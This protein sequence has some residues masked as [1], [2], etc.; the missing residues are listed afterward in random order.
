MAA[1]GYTPI[2]PYYSITATN[3]PLAANMVTGELAINTVDGK[4]YFKNSAGA[5]TLIAS[6]ASTAGNAIN[7]IGGGANQLIY[8]TGASTT[9]FLPAP[10]T[11]NTSLVWN[12]SSFSWGYPPIA[13]SVVNTV[14]VTRGGTGLTAPTLNSLLVGA[15]PN[16]PLNTIA[17]GTAGN[18]LTSSIST[19]GVVTGSISTTTLSVTAVTSGTLLIGSALSG[20]IGLVT[21]TLVTGQ[22]NASG[23]TAFSTATSIGGGVSGTN[24]IQFSSGTVSGLSVGNFIAGSGLATGTTVIAIGL[25]GVS[26]AVSNNFTVSAAVITGSIAGTTLNVTAVASGTLTSGLILSGTSVSSG[27][28]LSTQI[29]AIGATAFNSATSTGGGVLGTNSIQ[30]A[31]GVISTLTVGNFITGTGIPSGTSIIGI[32]GTTVTLSNVF[33]IAA[34]GTYSFYAAGKIG[35]YNVS[36]SQTAASQT[37]T[38]TAL[39]SYSFYTAGGIGTYVV[40]PSQTAASSTIT[41]TLNNWVSAATQP[42]G[43]LGQVFTSSGTFT[44]PAGVTALKVTVVGGGGSGTGYTGSGCCPTYFN[45]NAGG[46]SSVSSGTQTISTVSATGGGAGTSTY[47]AGAGGTGGLGSGGDLN[48]DGNSGS[49]ASSSGGGSLF[50]SA[51]N[52]DWGAGKSYGGG[53]RGANGSGAGGGTAIKYLTGLTPSATITVTRG[54]GGAGATATVPSGAGGNG[55][56]IFEW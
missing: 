22:T 26:I 11:P 56:I 48:M 47:G 19:V 21:P 14:P 43:M 2:Q 42:V 23:A 40:S 20:A 54:A 52:N 16:S 49:V 7:I 41:A 32:G 36:I 17:P 53:S 1:T 4:L 39:S 46:T 45:G 55:V 5:V 29:D 50:S 37:I 9:S 44:I 3:V 8:Q 38:A 15:G 10:G 27:T 33:S 28:A 31:S 6:T 13:G 24:V 35:N 25:D 34:S 18:V 30:F 12:G 51:Y